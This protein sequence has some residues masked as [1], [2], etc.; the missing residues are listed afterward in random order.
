MATKKPKPRGDTETKKEPLAL[1]DGNGSAVDCDNK[2]PE[3]DY[4][5]SDRD[6]QAETP[7]MSS[8][9]EDPDYMDRAERDPERPAD[10]KEIQGRYWCFVLYPD[11]APKNWMEILRLSGLRFA[12]SPLHDRDTCE[13]GSPKK[14]HYHVIVIWENKTTYRNVAEFTHKK[15]NATYPQKLAS[16]KGYF[17][18]FTHEDNPEKASY[19]KSDIENGN[20]FDIS[21]FASMTRQEKVEMKLD[22]THKIVEAGIINY[23]DCIALGESIGFD[24][25]DMVMSNTLYFTQIC[26]SVEYKLKGERE[27]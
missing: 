9:N 13:D 12:V 4:I 7:G 3:D 27:G 15:L 21:E 5:T 1:V 14:P 11:S 6:S 16:P 19:R 26:K 22:L 20:G 8:K 2:F 25:L 23:L 17:R 10:W 18:Y 24:E